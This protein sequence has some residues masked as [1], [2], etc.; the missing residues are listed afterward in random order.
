[1]ASNYRDELDH[2]PNYDSNQDSDS[3]ENRGDDL[4]DRMMG[5][6]K[7]GQYLKSLMAEVVE[8]KLGPRLDFIE[9]EIHNVKIKLD[10]VEVKANKNEHKDAEL[11]QSVS[12]LERD[13]NDLEQYGRRNS[14]RIH[15]VPESEKED[16]DELI[17]TIK[18]IAKDKLDIEL[19]DMDIDRTHRIGRASDKPRSILVKFTSYRARN[20]LIKQR[21]K[22][23][24]SKISIHEDLTKRNQELL[25]KTSKQLGVVSTWSQD[26]RVYASVM[27][28][29]PGKL[30]KVPIKSYSSWQDLPDERSYQEI[31]EQLQQKTLNRTKND[32]AAREQYQGVLTRNRTGSLPK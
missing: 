21:R 15:G 9:S 11:A 31:L 13:L 8:E 26:G 27:T 28:S 14:L 7:Y 3:E 5:S 16:A 24:G 23:K 4:T 32:S 18:T 25:M 2:S 30:A 12:K 20:I 6:R 29:T 22:L 19:Q 1:M 17:K 10:A